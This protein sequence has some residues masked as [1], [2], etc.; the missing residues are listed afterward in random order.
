MKGASSEQSRDE[1]GSPFRN[2]LKPRASVEHCGGDLGRVAKVVQ[3]N[4]GH[5]FSDGPIQ[6]HERGSGGQYSHVHAAPGTLP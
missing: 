5:L 6:H 2:P 4:V 1:V 3:K